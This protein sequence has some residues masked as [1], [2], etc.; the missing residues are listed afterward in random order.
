MQNLKSYIKRATEPQM[1]LRTEHGAGEGMGG[2]SETLVEESGCLGG[3]CVV[4][5]MRA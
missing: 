5:M 2:T 3:G 4:Q 1:V